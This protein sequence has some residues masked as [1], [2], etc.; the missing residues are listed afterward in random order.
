VSCCA[1][2]HFSNI[3]SKVSYSVGT[4][5][6]T[7]LLSCLHSPRCGCTQVNLHHKWNV[8]C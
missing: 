2:E 8:I 1:C 3:I 5:M 7:Q 4:G 6:A